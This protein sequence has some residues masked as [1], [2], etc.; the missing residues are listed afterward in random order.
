MASERRTVRQERQAFRE[1]QDSE[2]K[3]KVRRL[4]EGLMRAHVDPKDIERLER[5]YEQQLRRQ[6]G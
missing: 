6:H 3:D 5:Q 4:R 1:H 2:V